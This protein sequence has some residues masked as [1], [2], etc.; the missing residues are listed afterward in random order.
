MRR[1]LAEE[2][3]G[4]KL[5]IRGADARHIARVLRK[6]PGDEM[7]VA[8]G[9]GSATSCRIV[10]ADESEVVLERQG[11]TRQGIE[12]GRTV[13]LI[14]CLPKGQKMDF[15]IEKC[16]E[17]GFSVFYPAVSERCITREVSPSKAARW[18]KLAHE[19]AK[20]SGRTRIPVVAAP[21]ALTEALSEAKSRDALVLF[22]WESEIA[23]GLRAL[24]D[25]IRDAGEI[26]VV[27]GPEG[28]FSSQEADCAVS[29]G[30]VPVSLGPRVLRTETAPVAAGS[31]V[32]YIAGELGPPVV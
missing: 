6:A 4:G 25:R 19:A 13:S 11:S 18:Q 14:Q 12:A 10:S 16:T 20:Q 30:A 8:L 15:I 5:A 31:A 23:N 29:F 32:M 22:F 21:S 3:E 24:E 28:G 17:L 26:C 1:F 27:I 2:A 9:D 7:E